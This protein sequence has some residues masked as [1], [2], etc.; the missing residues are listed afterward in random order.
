[1]SRAR[2]RGVEEKQ[3]KKGQRGP[4]GADGEGTRRRVSAEKSVFLE[5]KKNAC[6]SST[7]SRTAAAVASRRVMPK[8]GD[9]HGRGVARTSSEFSPSTTD[10]T[11]A[12]AVSSAGGASTGCACVGG[13]WRRA[14]RGETA[15]AIVRIS[16]DY[17][18]RSVRLIG[19]D[20]AEEAKPRL[21][22][23]RAREGCDET[24]RP[25]SSRDLVRRRP[26]G[27]AR[28]A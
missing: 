1:M 28:R 14:A 23:L 11:T 13:G 10:S 12:S 19:P 3:G 2:G 21:C 22:L 15:S 4:A 9:D 16:I 26:G 25:H 8:A 20:D 18:S 24:R 17:A 6:P 27:D 7:F 5:R